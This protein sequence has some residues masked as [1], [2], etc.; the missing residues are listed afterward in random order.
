MHG[1]HVVLLPHMQA[2]LD[3]LNLQGAEKGFMGWQLADVQFVKGR[4]PLVREEPLL[5]CTLVSFQVLTITK[6]SA[7][8]S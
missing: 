1:L 3:V 7:S 6:T 8:L 2:Q 5:F 4:H